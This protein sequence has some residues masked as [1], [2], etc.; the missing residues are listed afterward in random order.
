MQD[1]HENCKLTQALL[2]LTYDHLDRI[3]WRCLLPALH[4]FLPLFTGK[5]F[6]SI[7]K[8]KFI[9]KNN[10]AKLYD[11]WLTSVKRKCERKP[12]WTLLIVWLRKL[13]SFSR[14]YVICP[15]KTLGPYQTSDTGTRGNAIFLLLSYG[16]S[17][18]ILTAKLH[19]RIKACWKV[20]YRVQIYSSAKQQHTVITFKERSR[21]H[22]RA[23]CSRDHVVELALALALAACRFPLEHPFKTKAFNY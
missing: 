10:K 7:H 23:V 18:K 6:I 12:K 15:S 14:L 20:T 19:L 8:G 3:M 21:I 17:W 5:G 11:R 1:I 2:F 4:N 22:R 9:K 13:K 16:K